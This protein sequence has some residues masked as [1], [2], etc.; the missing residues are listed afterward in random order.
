MPLLVRIKELFTEKLGFIFK[1]F[2]GIM[3]R[4][5]KPAKLFEIAHKLETMQLHTHKLVKQQMIL[6]TY[7]IKAKEATNPARA[8]TLTAPL[9][10]KK[11]EIGDIYYCTIMDLYHAKFRKICFRSLQHFLK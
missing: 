6:D 2:P 8:F 11:N 9:A 4:L 3:I 10:E 1:D 7:A 5:L